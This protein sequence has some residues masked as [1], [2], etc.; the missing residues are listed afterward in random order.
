MPDTYTTRNYFAHGGQELVI[1]GKL[2]FL[3][4]AEIEGMD[5]ALAVPST[6]TEFNAV[7]EFG[8]SVIAYMPDSEATTVAQL[9]D[10]HNRLLN[11]LRD[12]GIMAAEAVEA[13]EER[14]V[15]KHE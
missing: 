15:E 10:D 12:A 14:P 9:R 7:A 5:G 11:A 13:A 3:P 1:G 8:A 4:G 2:T 6:A